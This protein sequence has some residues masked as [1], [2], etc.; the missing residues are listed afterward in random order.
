MERINQYRGIIKKLFRGY[1][2][3]KPS[4]GDVQIELIF[5][6]SNDHYELIYSGWN[7]PYR[8]HGSILHIDIRSNKI[9][10][11]YDGTEDGIA[12]ELVKSGI[13]P[14]EIVLAFKEPSIRQYTGFAAA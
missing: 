8:I 10:V 13:P 4:R 11:Q 12:S 14:E 9:W 7:G 1:A 5:D 6:E 2:E 3:Y